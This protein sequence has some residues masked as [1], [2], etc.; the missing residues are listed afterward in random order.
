MTPASLAAVPGPGEYNIDRAT[1][2]NTHRNRAG[3]STPSSSFLCSRTPLNVGTHLETPA[4]GTYDLLRTEQAH[5]DKSGNVLKDP[6]FRSRTKRN[7]SFI[8]SSDVPGPGEYDLERGVATA[9]SLGAGGSRG[10]GTSGRPGQQRRGGGRHH[11]K[12][13]D[14]VSPGELNRI[15]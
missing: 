4:P 2:S 12:D 5:V 8:A 10:S 11:A 7:A 3:T 9:N 6:F 15:P 14:D 1:N 13:E